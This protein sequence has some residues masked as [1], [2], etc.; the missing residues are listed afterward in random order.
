MNNKLLIGSAGEF[1]VAG[2]ISRRGG[3]VALTRSGTIGVDILASDQNCSS[4]VQIQ[5]KT[6]LTKKN[7]WPL[8]QKAESFSGQNIFYIFVTLGNLGEYPNFFIVPSA[9][10]SSYIKKDHSNWIN[11]PGKNGQPHKDNLI[12]IFS[13]TDAQQHEY[14][15]RWDLLG[16]G[17]QFSLVL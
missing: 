7:K 10:V 12:R 3:I 4:S 9:H 17:L 2:E 15:N 13:I 5:V 6:S 8:S 1:F 11:K 16:L 14:F